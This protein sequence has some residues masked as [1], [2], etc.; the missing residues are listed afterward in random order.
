MKEEY[1]FSNAEQGKFYRPDQ[2]I[3][4]PIYVDGEVLAFFQKKSSQKNIGVDSLVN[5]ILKKEMEIIQSIE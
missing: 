2:R 4:A 1:D 3:E 5:S